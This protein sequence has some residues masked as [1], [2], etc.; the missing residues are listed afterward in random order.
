VVEDT[1]EDFVISVAPILQDA[2]W[3]VDCRRVPD[4][5]PVDARNVTPQQ[6]VQAVR[7][8]VELLL[9]QISPSLR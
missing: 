4:L 5:P 7:D 8:V 6:L 1:G 9:S 2:V 3:V